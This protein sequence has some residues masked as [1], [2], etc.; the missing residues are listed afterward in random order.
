MGCGGGGDSRGYV[1]LAG[2]GRG[3]VA[4]EQGREEGGGAV[5]FGRQDRR[6]GDYLFVYRGFRAVDDVCHFAPTDD[7]F[8]FQDEIPTRV[9]LPT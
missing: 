8:F 5:Q 9:K 6:Y 3:K 2:S 4:R 7:R 1:N